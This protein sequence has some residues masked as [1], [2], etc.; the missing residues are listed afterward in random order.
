MAIWRQQ[1]NL[2]CSNLQQWKRFHWNTLMLTWKSER[3]ADW[4][5][6]RIW[7]SRLIFCGSPTIASDYFWLVELRISISYRRS[8]N[9]TSK[10]RL[11]QLPNWAKVNERIRHSPTE[12]VGI[13][14]YWSCRMISSVSLLIASLLSATISSSNKSVQIIVA[15]P[16]QT[17]LKNVCFRFTESVTNVQ[18]LFDIF[19]MQ[20]Y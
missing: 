6:N 2:L 14:I 12:N 5:W 8:F 10:S 9:F 4:N 11:V 18:I 16:K 17:T 15:A 19:F 1:L 13:I 20:K 3:V 7:S